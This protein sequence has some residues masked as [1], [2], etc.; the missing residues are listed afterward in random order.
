[1]FGGNSSSGDT[2]GNDASSSSEDKTPA[3][4]NS[5]SNRTERPNTGSSGFDWGSMSGNYSSGNNQLTNWVLLGISVLVLA[6]VL[7]FAILYGRK[8]Y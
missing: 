6:G 3:G 8:R 2:E 5:G 7:V 1:M 4:D